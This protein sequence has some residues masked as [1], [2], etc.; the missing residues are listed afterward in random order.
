M[1]TVTFNTP[2]KKI[3]KPRL[4]PPTQSHSQVNVIERH[5]L[6]KKKYARDWEL[7]KK[8]FF[9]FSPCHVVWIGSY[10]QKAIQQFGFP[11]CGMAEKCYEWPSGPAKG[12]LVARQWQQ[13][14]HD[15][16]KRAV[17]TLHT[18]PRV[19]DWTVACRQQFTRRTIGRGLWKVSN[20]TVSLAGSKCHLHPD[21]LAQTS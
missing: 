9:F 19:F 8:S 3:P 18:S 14:G 2:G 1:N 11:G 7:H 6:K 4:F 12:S 13:L 16:K 10:H 20:L 17:R 21:G 5:R 15:P